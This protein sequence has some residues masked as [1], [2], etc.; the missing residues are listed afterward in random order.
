MARQKVIE[1]QKKQERP[2]GA[3]KAAKT[4][5]MKKNLEN[6]EVKRKPA[7]HRHGVARAMEASRLNK[8]GKRVFQRAPLVALVRQVAQEIRPETRLSKDFVNKLLAVVENEGLEM[9]GSARILAA[10]DRR[11]TARASDLLAALLVSRSGMFGSSS[12]IRAQMIRALC[13]EAVHYCFDPESGA[14]LIQPWKVQSFTNQERDP[15]NILR[16]V[17]WRVTWPQGLPMQL[18]VASV[19]LAMSSSFLYSPE[20]Q[21]R[22]VRLFM[23]SLDQVPKDKGPLSPVKQRVLIRKIAEVA[24]DPEGTLPKGYL[25]SLLAA[26]EEEEENGEEEEESRPEKTKTAPQPPPLAQAT[27]EE[28]DF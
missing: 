28:E 19:K 23:A 7:R 10:K 5:A 15:M 18:L 12:E 9:A 4:L 6:K 22:I 13:D 27:Q 17:E 3:G 2:Q 20:R 16:S 1:Q 8:S 11:S 14:T 25:A 24:Q 26:R 21:R